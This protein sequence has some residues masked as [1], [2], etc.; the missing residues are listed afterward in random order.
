MN[1]RNNEFLTRSQTNHLRKMNQKKRRNKRIRRFILALFA[2]AIVS[3]GMYVWYLYAQSKSAI[4]QSYQPT[5]KDIE[6]PRTTDAF[7]GEKSFSILLLGTD[8]G[9]EGR[10]ELNGNSDTIMVATVNPKTQKITLTSIPRDTMA[11]MV[12]SK[13][14]NIQKINAAYNIGGADMALSSA[15]ELLNIPL[16]YYMTINMGGLEQV[17]DAV[18]GVDVDVPF[19]FSYGWTN[20]KKGKMHLTGHGAL[21]YSRMRYE[22]P[23]GDYGRQKRQ[24]QVIEAILKNAISFNSLQNFQSILNSVSQNIRTNVTFDDMVSIF[25]H[26][27]SS[28]S[29]IESD[30]LHGMNAYIGGASYQVMATS[31]LQRVSDKLRKELSLPTEKIENNETRQNQL[32]TTFSFEDYTTDQTYYLYSK[33][34]DNLLWNGS[35]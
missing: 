13:N 30:Y 32:N 2:L 1:D 35:N 28:A 27:R 5:S 16:N 9:A 11:E 22:D 14:F 23:E 17:I 21:D 10:E 25:M 19:D 34:N 15:S 29:Q 12:S 8:T 20:F 24:R 26:Y 33:N 4:N 18:G 6:N 7:N 3:S 31:E